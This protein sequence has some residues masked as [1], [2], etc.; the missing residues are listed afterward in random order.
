MQLSPGDR[1]RCGPHSKCA[2]IRIVL[3]IPRGNLD[4]GNGR[5]PGSRPYMH[6]HLP[7]FTVAARPVFVPT[8]ND[9]PSTTAAAGRRTICCL[10]TSPMLPCGSLHWYTGRPGMH[11]T[12]YSD[13]IAQVLHLFPFSRKRPLPTPIA[14]TPNIIMRDGS[15]F[16]PSRTFCQESV[17]KRPDIRMRSPISASRCCPCP[18]QLSCGGGAP[19]KAALFPQHFLIDC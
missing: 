19:H 5:F 3:P 6:P 7:I 11:D 14:H 9:T 8:S 16:K 13:E 4:A 12:D 17:A 1:H 18:V 2:V 15:F 10:D